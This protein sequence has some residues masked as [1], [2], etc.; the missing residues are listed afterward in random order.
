MRHIRV[1]D[2]VIVVAKGDITADSSEVVVCPTTPQLAYIGDV[3]RAVSYSAGREVQQETERWV[4]TNGQLDIGAVLVTRSGNLACK[5]LIHAVSPTYVGSGQGIEKQL[6]TVL[7]SVLV[8]ADELRAPSIAI[9][10]LVESYPVNELAR[11]YFETILEYLTSHKSNISQ[12][13]FLNFDTPTVDGFI[14]EFDRR[15]PASA[16]MQR[17]FSGE[18]IPKSIPVDP[19]QSQHVCCMLL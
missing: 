16:G 3:A 10:K 13:Q 19:Q 6:R 17:Y 9:P 1:A 15:F 7:K 12:I 4:R 2:S 5:Q 8:K 11:V 14:T 18:I